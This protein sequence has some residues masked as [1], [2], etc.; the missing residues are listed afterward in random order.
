MLYHPMNTFL[1][2]VFSMSIETFWHI[3]G[4]HIICLLPCETY[5]VGCE[6]KCKLRKQRQHN[7]CV[8]HWMQMRTFEVHWYTVMNVHTKKKKKKISHW[9]TL[10]VMSTL[11]GLW[12]CSQSDRSFAK[13]WKWLPTRPFVLHS[14]RKFDYY[15]GGNCKVSAKSILACT[16]L[17]ELF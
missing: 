2:I 1:I 7:Q 3:S 11:F 15:I 17:T 12:H 9:E 6:L 10:V 5:S 14:T 13:N 4:L 16:T 8:D